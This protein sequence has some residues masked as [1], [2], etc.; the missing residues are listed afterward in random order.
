MRNTKQVLDCKAN[1]GTTMILSTKTKPRTEARKQ[2]ML[3]IPQIKSIEKMKKKDIL[4]NIKQINIIRNLLK[5]SVW[6]DTLLMNN[7]EQNEKYSK[8]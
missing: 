2:V 6:R 4:R 5:G 8:V 7:T 3:N 1:K